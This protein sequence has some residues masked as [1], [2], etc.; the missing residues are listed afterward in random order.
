MSDSSV[1]KIDRSAVKSI[2]P[3]DNQQWLDLRLNDIT[4]TEIA[5]LFGCSPYLTEFE[6][7]HQ[8]KSRTIVTSEPNERMT[9]GLRL[10]DAIAS[11][12]AIDKGWRINRIDEYLRDESRRMG[13]SFDFAIESDGLLEIKN[14]DSLAFKNGWIVNGDHIEAPPHIELQLQHQLAVS[15][16]K[17]SICG[18]LVGGNRLE[19]IEREPDPKIISA[20]HDKVAAFWESIGRNKPPEPNFERD[21]EVIAKLYGASEKNKIIDLSSDVELANLAYDYK[22]ASE[23]EKLAKLKREAI[24]AKLLMKIGDAEKV[25]SDEFSISAG[26]VQSSVIET[27]ERAAY[28]SFRI[29][30]KKTKELK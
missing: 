28:R 23:R 18:A 8:K 30:W 21:A 26:T 29:N 14:V 15:G 11:G 17:Y 9:W 12:I 25:I 24:K 10:Q 4:S 6:L 13:A 22:E 20:I 19:Y 5:A 7:W 3:T 27:Y 16:R 1:L 2:L